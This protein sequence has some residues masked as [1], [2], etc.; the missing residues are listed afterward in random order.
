MPFFPV[1]ALAFPEFTNIANGFFSSLKAFL[2]TFF[3]GLL[4]CKW[5]IK[6]VEK[7]KLSYFSYYC[8]GLSVLLI[9]SYVK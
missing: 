3:V 9:L 6:I 2:V 1:N 7:N 4:C 5:M 8:F